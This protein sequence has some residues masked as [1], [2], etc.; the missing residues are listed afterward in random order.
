MNCPI[1]AEILEEDRFRWLDDV[2]VCDNCYEHEIENARGD[3]DV[4]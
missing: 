2:L 3:K 4:N 1:C